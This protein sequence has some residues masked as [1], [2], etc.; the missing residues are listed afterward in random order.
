[1]SELRVRITEDMKMAMRQKE[2]ERLSVI[3]MILARLK[4]LDIEARGAGKPEID[5]ETVLQALVKMVKQRKEAAQTY[6]A[7]GRPE[8]AAKE[9]NEITVI[10]TYLPQTLSEDALKEAIAGAKAKL[11]AASPADMGKM[12]AFLKEHY[13]GQIDFAVASGLIK[14]SLQP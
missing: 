14:A 3:R 4:D 11:G 7:G 5:E 6:E 2:A 12:I 1:M 10:E 8:L 13:P 9:L